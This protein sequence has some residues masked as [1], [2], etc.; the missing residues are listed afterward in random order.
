MTTETDYEKIIIT[1]LNEYL[2]EVKK[3]EIIATIDS[4]L[5]NDLNI[6]SLDTIELAFIVEE[7]F[8]IDVSIDHMMTMQLTTVKDIIE[9]FKTNKN[10]TEN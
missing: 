8:G 4:H 2:K 10:V 7:K 5:I 1:S 6:D 9:F 3:K